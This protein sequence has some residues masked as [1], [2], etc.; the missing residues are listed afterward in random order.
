MKTSKDIQV[1]PCWDG[2]V[3]RVERLTQLDLADA[4][5]LEAAL[6]ESQRLM[7]AI[8]HIRHV[9]MQAEP[10]VGLASSVIE[11]ESLVTDEG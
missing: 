2:L 7:G 1:D 10:A 9:L 4:A 5:G 8:A 3:E 6:D 11:I